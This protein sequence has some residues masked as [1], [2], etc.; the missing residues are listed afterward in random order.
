MLNR[1]VGELRF[2]V[3]MHGGVCFARLRIVTD[4]L[5]RFGQRPV[6]PKTMRDISVG[7]SMLARI[8][9]MLTMTSLRMNSIA[10]G[11][12]FCLLVLNKC[13]LVT[14]TGLHGAAKQ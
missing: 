3:V 14:G 5:S 8:V 2:R 1:L 7:K 9:L 6:L 4:A 12:K 10:S 13:S 11:G